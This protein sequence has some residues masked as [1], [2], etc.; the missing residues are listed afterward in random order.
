MT[1]MPVPAN[2][3]IRSH[4]ADQPWLRRDTAMLAS[5]VGF[6]L[7]LRC[8]FFTGFFGSDEVT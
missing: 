2:A 3:A 1:G 4:G 6:A 8:L 5:I 7:L